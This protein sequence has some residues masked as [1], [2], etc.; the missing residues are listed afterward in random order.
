MTIESTDP[1]TVEFLRSFGEGLH[2]LFITSA[3]DLGP[4]GDG[5][6]RSTDVP[7]LAVGVEPAAGSKCERCWNFTE[8]IGDD[9]DWPDVCAR[10]A[11]SIRRIVSERDPA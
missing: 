7:G 6:I 2:F 4:A 11:T 3:V 5:A 9:K 10:C 1:E 8:D